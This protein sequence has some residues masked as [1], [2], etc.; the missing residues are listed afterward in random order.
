V[1][2]FIGMA[3]GL[4][5]TALRHEGLPL[6]RIRPTIARLE[7]EFGLQ[8]ALANRRLFTDGTEVL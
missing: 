3:E 8:H 5:L 1:I 7:Q 4:V 2:P 6:Q